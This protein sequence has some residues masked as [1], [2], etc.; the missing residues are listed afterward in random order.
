MKRR[1]LIKTGLLGLGASAVALSGCDNKENTSSEFNIIPK[2]T[3][4]YEISCPLPFSY[5][6]IDEIVEMNSKY[7]KIQLTSFYNGIPYP[8]MD[9]YNSWVHTR[10]GAGNES[11]KTLDDFGKYVKYALERGFDFSYL[12]NSPKVFS[13]KDYLTIKNDL[14]YLI[15]Y[16][17]KI[18]CKNIKVSNMQLIDMLS[19]AAPNEFKLQVS[20][21]AE[22]HNINQYKNL[23]AI[24]KNFN[25]ID[26]SKD[27]NQNFDLLKNLRKTFPD[28]KIEVMINE[29]CVKFCPGRISHH[30]EMEIGVFNCNNLARIKGDALTSIK[31]GA[32]F[33]WDLKYYSTFGINNFKYVAE[34]ILSAR[35]NFYDITYLDNYFYIVENGYDRERLIKLFK[36]M[37][38]HKNILD[39]LEKTKDADSEEIVSLLPDIRYFIKH[40]HEC[41]TK[42]ETECFYCNHIAKRIENKVLHS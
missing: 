32:I 17:K 19:K 28:M 9:K 42:C 10:R 36:S 35:D 30:Q 33:P 5:K 29:G 12:M 38:V 24:Y 21:T 41:A 20:T 2:Q 4:T 7:K 26:I 22:Y 25:L 15:D 3:G 1:D 8:L 23:F 14:L 18:G 6:T 34:A 39:Y 31:A 13:K 11:I 16:L 27:D 37:G 40:G